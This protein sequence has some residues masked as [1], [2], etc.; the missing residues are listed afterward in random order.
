MAIFCVDEA[1]IDEYNL[2]HRCFPRG[3][4][5]HTFLVLEG[6][7]PDYGTDYDFFFHLFDRCKGE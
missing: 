1:S 2:P 5:T 3:S 4:G 7:A 6:E